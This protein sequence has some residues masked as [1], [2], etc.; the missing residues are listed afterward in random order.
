MTPDQHIRAGRHWL[1]SNLF[2]GPWGTLQ[3]LAAVSVG[4]WIAWWLIDLAITDADWTYVLKHGL[5]LLIGLYP[6]EQTWRALLGLL[7]LSA[8]PFALVRMP[9]GLWVRIAFWIFVICLVAWLLVDGLDP[10]DFENQP[11][12]GMLLTLLFASAAIAFGLPLGLLFALMRRSALPVVRGVAIG[13]GWIF[14]GVPSYVLLLAALNAP[15]LLPQAWNVAGATP[16]ALALLMFVG[17]ASRRYADDLYDGLMSIPAAQRDI[18]ASLGLRPRHTLRAIMI[19]QALLRRIPAL[20]EST[21]WT[22]TETT[23]VGLLVGLELVG[24]SQLVRITALAAPGTG[25]ILVAA[26]VFYLVVGLAVR[27]YGNVLARRAAARLAIRP[28]TGRQ[29]SDNIVV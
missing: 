7:I 20:V 22:I 14:R 12:S 9:A 10:A 4:G 2:Y 26:A 24:M 16:L 27:G 25:T 18:A 11:I 1:R 5:R 13:L 6:Q 28:M 23:I 29:A 3:S 19:P 8:I 15:L 21:V 17:I